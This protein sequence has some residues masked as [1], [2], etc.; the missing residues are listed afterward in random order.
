MRDAIWRF[1]RIDKKKLAEFLENANP[2]IIFSQRKGN[3]KMCRLEYE[4]QKI[5]KAPMVAYTGDNEYLQDGLTG[6]LIQKLHYL[7]IRHWLDKM[8]P[9]YRLYYSMSEEQMRFYNKKFGI[10]TKFLVKCGEFSEKLIHKTINTPIRLVYA[11]KLYCGRG[12]TL[13]LLT[14]VFKRS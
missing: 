7:W 2:D 12:A 6:T 5:S 8:I 9:T 11:G 3:V 14:E 10:N 13:C 4:I 1:G